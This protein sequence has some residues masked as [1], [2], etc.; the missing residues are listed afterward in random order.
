[1]DAAIVAG[2]AALLGLAVGRFWDTHAE[3]RR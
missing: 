3:A 2:L 1:M